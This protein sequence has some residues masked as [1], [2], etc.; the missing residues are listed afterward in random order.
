[1]LVVAQHEGDVLTI[2]DDIR[3]LVTRVRGGT[4][5]MSIDA[6]AHV[7]IVRVPATELVARPEPIVEVLPA[8]V[9]TRGS[10]PGS[11]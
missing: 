1:M 8:Y 7:A 3:I 4:V 10:R 11:R 5:K 2:G 9:T 6:P